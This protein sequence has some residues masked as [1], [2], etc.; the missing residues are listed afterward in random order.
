MKHKSRNMSHSVQESGA[1]GTKLV[2]D[3]GLD[4]SS[5]KTVTKDQL[6]NSGIKDTGL[7]RSISDG[8]VPSIG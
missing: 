2:T 6:K 1:R 5:M 4:N 8:K 3:T 7:S